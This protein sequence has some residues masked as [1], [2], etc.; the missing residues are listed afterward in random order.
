MAK[1]I[2]SYRISPDIDTLLKAEAERLSEELGKRTSEADVIEMAVA[3]WMVDT[4]RN[5]GRKPIGAYMRRPEQAVARNARGIRE[6][7]DK[8]R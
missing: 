2:R 7:G 1:I 5:P 6:K 8:S 3:A 4:N